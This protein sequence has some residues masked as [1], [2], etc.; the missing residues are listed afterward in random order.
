MQTPNELNVVMQTQAV[1]QTPNW[2]TTN[3]KYNE[4]MA[5][6]L[7]LTGTAVSLI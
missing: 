1:M 6:M 5:S 4:S 3:D 2:N 7:S